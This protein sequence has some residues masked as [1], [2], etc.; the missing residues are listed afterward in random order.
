[1]KS[2][3]CVWDA[4][5]DLGEGV[6]WH[7]EERSVYWVDIV[8]SRLYRLAH[9]GSFSAWE[10]PGRLSAVMPCNT[11]GLIATFA[12]GIRHID[13]ATA[14]VGKLLPLEEDRPEN[15]FNDGHTDRYGQFWFGSMD[16]R[17]IEE[18]GCF[19]RMNELG[20]V[21]RVNNFGLMCIT[22]GPAFS[23]D[24]EWIFYTDTVN[25]KIYRAPL[26]LPTFPGKP[27]L[28]I[29][30]SRFQGYPDGMCT[31]TEGGLWVCHFAGS[32]ISRFDADGA[33]D[34]EILLPVP[35]VTK[36]AFGGNDLR[37][38]Y[39]TTAA[40]G[41]TAQERQTHPL[42]GGLFAIDVPFEG[43]YA[44]PAAPPIAYHPH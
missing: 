30:F 42:S 40:K 5:A 11:G 25:R 37:T 15:R 31:D 16:D 9:D 10:F 12:N 41:L 36:C 23:V 33:F 2:L 29:D 27:T 8:Q 20:V 6:F 1:M 43:A 17:E 4:K 26:E 19:Y 3:T 35:N 14:Y 7:R 18:S 39:I 34:R 24:A 38:L 21:H 22:N 13:P 44:L 28:F 32:R